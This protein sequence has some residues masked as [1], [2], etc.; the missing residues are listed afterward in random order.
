[1]SDLFLRKLATTGPLAA[2]AW[3]MQ[4]AIE[5]LKPGDKLTQAQAKLNAVTRGVSL[6]DEMFY[7]YEAEC[8]RATAAMAENAKLAA[9][10][11]DLKKEV[12]DL[13][14]TIKNLEH[15]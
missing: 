12:E 5:G 4:T 2:M 1:M 10:V 3:Q 15:E 6:I 11:A 9:Q 8:R 7:A 14:A 13:K